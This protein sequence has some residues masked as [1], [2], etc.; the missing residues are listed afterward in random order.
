MDVSGTPVIH[1]HHAKD[2][3]LGLRDW[4]RCTELVAWPNKVSLYIRGRGGRERGSVRE[5]R[6]RKERGSVKEKRERKEREGR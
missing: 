4:D 5:K 2:V 1:E 6:G 3:L